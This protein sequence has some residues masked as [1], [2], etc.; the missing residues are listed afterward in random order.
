MNLWAVVLK[1]NIFCAA[2]GN[3]VG[4]G[5]S[6]LLWELGRGQGGLFRVLPHTPPHAPPFSLLV[7][8]ENPFSK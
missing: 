8:V 6:T 7:T 2:V 4:G 5:G 3:E 1:R